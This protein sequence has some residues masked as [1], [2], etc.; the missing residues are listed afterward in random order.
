MAASSRS[1]S[2]TESSLSSRAIRASSSTES[3][4]YGQRHTECLNA[5]ENSDASAPAARGPM[6]AAAPAPT[7]VARNRLRFID[8]GSEIPALELAHGVIDRTRRERHV[9][10]RGVLAGRARHAGAIGHV[11]VRRVVQLVV[12]IERGGLRIAT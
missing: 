3:L 6:K 8:M 5:A 4:P 7:P 2:S 1:R 10:D 9:R 12:G 11:D